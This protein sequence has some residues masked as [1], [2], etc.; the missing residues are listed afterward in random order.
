LT[1]LAVYR[2]TTSKT[3][4]EGNAPPTTLKAVK[5]SKRIKEYNDQEIE[6]TNSNLYQIS[7][8]SKGKGDLC[9][10]HIISVSHPSQESFQTKPISTTFTT[11]I[12][13]LI[14]KPIIQIFR[15]T[16]GFK[17]LD[18]SIVVVDMH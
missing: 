11:P 9:I 6:D 16:V 10:P 4:S 7:Q 5:S 17:G 1:K 8:V 2:K 12:L 13:S 3:E 15:E 14:C 18:Q